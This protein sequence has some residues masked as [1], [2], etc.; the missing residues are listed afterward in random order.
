MSASHVPGT[1][2]TVLDS[3]G[4]LFGRPTYRTFVSLVLG[5]VLCRG[6]HTI[7]RVIL[8]ARATGADGHHARFYRFFAKSVW[9]GDV[10]ELGRRVLAL[11]LPLLPRTIELIVDDTLCRKGGP[12]VFGAA[13][14]H[15]AVASSYGGAGGA[16]RVLSF[17]HNWVV[18]SVRVPVP[19]AAGRA[20]AV[21]LLARLYRGKKRTPKRQYRKRTE[22]ALAMLE[23][24]L[25]WLPDDRD[26]RV[27]G[28]SA[29]TC[30]TLVRALPE[31]VVF[32]GPVIMNAALDE[33]PPPYAGF[34][35]PRLRG[36]RLPSPIL[37]RKAK[38]SA[39]TPIETEIY[40]RTVS[41]LVQSV[42]CLWWT[43][44][45]SRKVRVVLA[46]D[47]SGRYADRAFFATDPTLSPAAILTLVSH[48]WDL[49]VTF[50]DLKQL[51]GLADPQNGW[52]RRPAGERPKKRRPGPARQRVRARN[53]VERT[54]PFVLAV[55]GIV[56]IWYLRHGHAA[57]DVR[58]VRKW[59]PWRCRKRS[60]SFADMLAALRAEILRERLSAY[61]LPKRVREKVLRL[62]LPLCGAAA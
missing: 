18:L 50:R 30:R 48:R 10:D 17:G 29:Y 32:A 51:L 21:P 52:W 4:G 11:L 46:R 34:G 3:F 61:P 26:V 47:P 22:Q 12:Q 24:V 44:A 15:D 54:V 57:R 27:L 2:A 42:E 43:V 16:Q 62:V 14:H 6:R 40:G 5:W 9:R 35:R 33:P 20:I 28:D 58:A 1:L 53:A 60:P 56:V 41:L 49:E 31:H 38:K 13:M 39:W 7:T 25:E 55:Y 23:R 36:R 19:W 59:A 37:L 8:A 45:K